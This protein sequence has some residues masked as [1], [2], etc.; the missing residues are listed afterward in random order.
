MALFTAAGYQA[1][2]C[3]LLTLKHKRM[4][5]FEALLPGDGTP[6]TQAQMKAA[7]KVLAAQY[8]GRLIKV[9]RTKKR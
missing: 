6:Q 2:K 1:V 8:G 3:W 9:H 7:L 4:P 5:K